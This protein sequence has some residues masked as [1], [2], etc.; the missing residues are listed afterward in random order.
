MVCKLLII[1]DDFTGA[2]DTG[3]QLSK[4]GIDTIVYCDTHSVSFFG[5]EVVVVNTNSRHLS[6]TEAGAIVYVV[7][8]LAVEAGVEYFYKK[9]DSALRGNIGAEL[10][11]IHQA[12]LNKVLYFVPAYPKMNRTTS[13][14]YHYIDGIKVASS[15]FGEDPF[16]PVTKSFLPDFFDDII[17]EKIRLR[18]F[19]SLMEDDEGIVVV[20]ASS[21]YEL[22]QIAQ[23]MKQKEIT[24]FAGCAGFGEYLPKIL[25]LSFFEYTP[26]PLSKNIL[27][28]SASL[29]PKS[30]TQLEYAENSGFSCVTLEKELKID[31]GFTS[32]SGYQAVVER[33]K[34]LLYDNNPVILRSV[35]TLEDI[36]SILGESSQET[37]EV[38][39]SNFAV[40]VVDILRSIEA[41][42]LI[43]GGDLLYAVIKEM[44][45]ES[46]VPRREILPGV[47]EFEVETETDKKTIISKSGGFGDEAYVVK[48]YNYICDS[49]N[50]KEIGGI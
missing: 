4:I 13:C 38:V 10:I 49:D 15:I 45:I 33:I 36:K 42:P 6:P 16:N 9:T 17:D 27:V 47:A 22:E 18:S 20:D 2:V 1:A 46:V 41:T 19:N 25:D 24:I 43:F 37:S 21:D 14:G 26:R 28:V 31:K 8:K 23:W 11:A 29:N 30:I 12:A 44:G 32:S 48:I 39:A 5:N 34:R 40:I 35:K 3:V 50:L 7:T